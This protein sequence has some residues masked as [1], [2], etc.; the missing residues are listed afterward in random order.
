M[1]VDSGANT[2]LPNNTFELE[3][4]KLIFAILP[5]P[6]TLANATLFA[7]FAIFEYEA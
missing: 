2:P 7:V 6:T 4:S 5:M 3:P 1:L